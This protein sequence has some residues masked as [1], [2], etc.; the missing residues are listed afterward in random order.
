MSFAD[1]L[2]EVIQG[3]AYGAYVRDK[4]LILID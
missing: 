3:L 4:G 2:E 1:L